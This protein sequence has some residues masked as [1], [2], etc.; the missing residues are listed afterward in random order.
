MRSKECFVRVFITGKKRK[1][2]EEGG[3]SF[4]TDRNYGGK[5]ILKIKRL[6]PKGDLPQGEGRRTRKNAT[7]EKKA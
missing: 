3:S 7:G 5:K 2:Q 6:L 4:D 1:A